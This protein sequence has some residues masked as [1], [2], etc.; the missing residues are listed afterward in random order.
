M[1]AIVDPNDLDYC[2]TCGGECVADCKRAPAIHPSLT[3]AKV[4]R[5]VRSNMTGDTFIGFCI[6]CG[7]KA[8]QPCEPDARAYPCQFKACGKN[9]VYGAEE[10]LFM[11]Q[12]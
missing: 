1:N 8:K 4:A 6:A 12:A 10:L 11:V 2:E 3:A 9:A 5:A 7:R